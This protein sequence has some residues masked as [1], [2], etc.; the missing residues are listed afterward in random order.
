MW[1]TV[2]GIEIPGSN[3]MVHKTQK[4]CATIK[5]INPQNTTWMLLKK[6]QGITHQPIKS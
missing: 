2:K 6:V 1:D 4:P 5:K 3:F